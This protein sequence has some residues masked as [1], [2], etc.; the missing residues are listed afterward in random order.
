MSLTVE[1]E[2]RRSAGWLPRQQ[3]LEEWLA[4][5]EQ[6][7]AD[8]GDDRLL[9]PTLQALQA[10]IEDDPLIGMYARRMIEE[11]PP[12]KPYTRRHLHNPA[13]M[14][15]LLDAVM[16]MAPEFG[17]QAV[18][19]PMN[20][21]LDWT[22]G[23]P[24][25][26]SFYRHPQVNA[27][28]KAVLQGWGDY[29]NSRA[30]LTSL[31]P[32]PTGW[33]SPAAA[34]AIGIEQYQ[35]DPEDPHWGFVSWNDFFTRRFRDGQRPVAAP[36]DDR[37]IVS[38]C[39]STPYALRTGVQRRDTFWVKQQPYSLD[40][41]LAGDPS[42]EAFVGGTVYQAFLS[43]TEYHRWHSP[44]SGTV[45]SA[46]VVDGTYFSEADSEGPAAVEPQNSQ[47]YLA[48]VAARA[49]I[50]LR[51]DNP[52]IGEIAVVAV[53]MSDVSTCVLHPDLVPGQ[54]LAKGDELGHF[55]FGGSTH[56]LVL[57]PG[58]VDSFA[59]AALPSPVDRQPGPVRVRATLA[60]AGTR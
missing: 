48:H 46:R 58:A 24:S 40:E 45:L 7:V 38:A 49:V 37:V 44:V 41:L 4:G 55:A 15:R 29:L 57:R 52:A 19:L 39:E 16:T 32:S 50:V 26:F 27:A 59:F 5:H 34:R 2:V 60:Y 13:Q 23:T 53:G 9:H 3:D 11:V 28:L 42:V 6:R 43:A 21:V 51:A 1:S 20:A 30:S 17:D 22:M 8:L 54:H 33:T 12:A 47:G 36:D 31:N 35:H 25:G 56:C 14:L 18:T 10:L